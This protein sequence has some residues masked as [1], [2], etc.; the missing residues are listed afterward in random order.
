MKALTLRKFL[1][2]T[3]AGLF[4]IAAHAGPIYTGFFSNTAVGG[5]DT[6]SYHQG[7][8]VKGDK[9]YSTEWNGADWHFSSAENLAL[10]ESD[11]EAY[12]PAYGGH[13]AWA[14][15]TKNDLVKGDPT[16]WAIVDGRL[17]LNYNK[18]VQT[19]WNTDRPGF[20]R[21]ADANWPQH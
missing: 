2:A 14:L 5:Y 13:C 19:Q 18:S 3:A 20:I 9:R 6:V 8:P 1:L 21:Q 7:G 16:V 4:S 15:A 17:Y 10:F 11:P 12:A